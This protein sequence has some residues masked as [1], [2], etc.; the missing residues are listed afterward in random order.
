MIRGRD[1]EIPRCPECGQFMQ[2]FEE[3]NRTRIY[4]CCGHERVLPGEEEWYAYD[5]L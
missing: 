3:V 5:R 4:E 2:L 1:R